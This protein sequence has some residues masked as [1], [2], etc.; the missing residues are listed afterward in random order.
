MSYENENGVTVVESVETMVSYDS[1]V[2]TNEEEK[3]TLTSC[4]H[5][6]YIFDTEV[7]PV[8]PIQHIY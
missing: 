2:F 8:C 5:C 7:Y 6:G 1:S 3:F 4:T